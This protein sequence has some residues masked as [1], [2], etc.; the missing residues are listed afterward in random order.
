VVPY[1]RYGAAPLYHVR[2]GRY[3]TMEDGLQV[4]KRLR[5]EPGIYDAVVVSD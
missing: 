3:S 1:Q 5:S 4:A 2:V